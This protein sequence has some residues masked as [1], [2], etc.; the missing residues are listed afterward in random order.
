VGEYFET[1][2]PMPKTRLLEIAAIALVSIA[3]SLRII[4]EETEEITEG[5]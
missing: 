1:D 3:E 2:P 4:A 5:D